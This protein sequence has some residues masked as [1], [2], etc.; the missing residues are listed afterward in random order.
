[1]HLS[2]HLSVPVLVLSTRPLSTIGKPQL[3]S[4]ARGAKEPNFYSTLFVSPV[5]ASA[6]VYAASLAIGL[7]GCCMSLLI[8]ETCTVQLVL[9][10]EA[11]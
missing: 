4:A 8:L 7:H 6:I 3:S 9:T 1:M 10:V 2:M 11:A 5:H